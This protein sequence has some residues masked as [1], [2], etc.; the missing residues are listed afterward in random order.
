MQ[1]KIAIPAIIL[2]FLLSS[3]VFAGEGWRTDIKVNL[4][5]AQNRVSI[6]QKPDAADGWDTRYDVP[7]MLF[8]DIMAY[9]EEPEGRKYWR[10]FRSSCNGYPCIKK[11]DLLVDSEL[12]G[13]IIKLNWNSSSFPSGTKIL[14]IDNVTG[15]VIDMRAQ[16]EYSYKNIGKRKFQVEVQQ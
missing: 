13:Q 4:M 6:G 5:D 3:P 2:W 1:R 7:A 14:L 9:I 15:N 10:K 16:T 12:E 11:W 8:G